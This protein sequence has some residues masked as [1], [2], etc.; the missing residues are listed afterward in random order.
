MRQK[1]SG[2]LLLFCWFFAAV[3]LHANSLP[4]H[5][6]CD[7]AAVIAAQNSAVPLSVLMSI[8]RVESGRSQDGQVTPWPWAANLAG[9]SYFFETE[10][11]AIEFAAAQIASGNINFDIGCFQINLRWHSRG[12]RSLQAAYDPQN[13]ANYAAKFLSELYQEKGNWAG[14]VAAY[15]SRSAAR[16]N[17]YLEKVTSTWHALRQSGGSAASPQPVAA[18]QPEKSV[19]NFP[20]LRHGF[21]ANGSLVPQQIDNNS[22]GML[23]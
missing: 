6:Q 7:A 18:P 22:L 19:N 3:P 12:F 21:G 4:P 15:H 14:A 10:A 9:E 8:A 5:Q 23:R 17:R 11:K 16:A 20:L 2:K 1:S 13:N